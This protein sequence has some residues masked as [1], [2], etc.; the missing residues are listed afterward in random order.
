[1]SGRCTSCALQL[2][3]PDPPGLPA[4][5]LAADAPG[6]ERLE[7]GHL[8]VADAA[9]GDHEALKGG[10]KVCLGR[11]P[12]T[13]GELGCVSERRLFGRREERE[14]LQGWHEPGDRSAGRR[15]ISARRMLAAQRKSR[16]G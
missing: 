5:G 3:L 10:R 14:E 8:G 7:I 4:L 6:R 12:Q 16:C 13:I 2:A 11:G 1:M 15:A 9:E